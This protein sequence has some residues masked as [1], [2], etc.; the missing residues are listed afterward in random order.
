MLNDFKCCNKYHTLTNKLIL[1]IVATYS[2]SKYIIEKPLKQAVNATLSEAVTKSWWCKEN[3]KET[4]K[5]RIWLL[6]SKQESWENVKMM[7]NKHLPWAGRNKANRFLHSSAQE[8][9][10]TIPVRGLQALH[11]LFFYVA[12]TAHKKICGLHQLASPEVWKPLLWKLD[13]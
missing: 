10:Q 2:I 7:M 4:Q 13:E 11:E 12:V 9:A 3:T 1:V 6:E 8:T 5:V